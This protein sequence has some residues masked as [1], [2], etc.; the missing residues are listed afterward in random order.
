[1]RKIILHT[2]LA[3]LLFYISGCAGYKPIFSSSGLKFN[4]MDYSIEGEKKLGK[5]IYSKIYNLSQSKK[6]ESDSKNID[7]LIK[8]SKNKEAT[9]KSSTG[10]ILNYKITLNT[11]ISVRDISTNN[12]ILESNISYSDSYKV[13]D[14]YSETIQ[15][16]NKSIDNLINKIFQDILIE[17]TTALTT[18]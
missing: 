8:V 6:E 17:L 5:K 12:Q 14:Q 16:E 2:I 15:L 10:K 18:Q 3:I 4:I 11:E 1:M 13:Q 9:V 7:L